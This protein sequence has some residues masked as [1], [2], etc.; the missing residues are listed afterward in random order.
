[1]ARSCGTSRT[2]SFRA[3]VSKRAAPP[4]EPV[5]AVPHNQNNLEEMC[6]R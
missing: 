2:G 6:F 3:G 1:M 5:P 4:D